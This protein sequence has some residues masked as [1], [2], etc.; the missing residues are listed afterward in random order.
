M[1][2]AT[3]S[4]LK[5]KFHRKLNQARKSIGTL[6]KDGRNEHF[7]YNYIKNEHVIAHSMKA[8]QDQGLS[9]D[10]SMTSCKSEP[11]GA[12]SRTGAAHI[13][14]SVRIQFEIIDTETG[15]SE[16][17]EWNGECI[18]AEDKGTQKAATSARKYFLIQYM[19]IVTDEVSLDTD[20]TAHATDTVA[21]SAPKPT[22]E[23]PAKPKEEDVA[24]QQSTTNTGQT[25]DATKAATNEQ[26]ITFHGVKIE[27][28]TLQGTITDA[29]RQKAYDMMAKRHSASHDQ[30]HAI[31]QQLADLIGKNL[32]DKATWVMA[33]M[34]A[35]SALP[36]AFQRALAATSE[37]AAEAT[38]TP[39]QDNSNALNLIEETLATANWPAFAKSK[40]L[41]ILTFK[42]KFPEVRQASD[43]NE[44]NAAI[45]TQYIQDIINEIEPM[46]KT[47]ERL[48][49][50]GSE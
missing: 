41:Y 26:F 13:R 8:L 33:Y 32:E 22:P 38:T 40:G 31:V 21:E 4:Q 23:R 49:S 27:R 11:T 29:G 17:K 46:P 5:A 6:A 50:K 10:V 20:T 43:I 42:Q 25:S 19:G 28:S 44:E 14:T 24:G 7:K 30:C 36:Q 35:E 16:T 15:Y 3:T 34:F 48:L 39:I 2:E 18:E 9:I 47:L 12:V 37:T 1:A 45:I